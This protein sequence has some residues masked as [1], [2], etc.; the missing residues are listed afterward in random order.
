M[1][2]QLLDLRRSIKD[3]FI[4]NNTIKVDILIVKFFSKTS[5]VDF[6][7]ITGKIL[8]TYLRVNSNILTKK[9]GQNY[10]PPFKQYSTKTRQD[11]K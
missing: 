10:Q 5:I 4:N 2:P 1:D 6:N 8:V 9:N 3:P 11:P 7:N